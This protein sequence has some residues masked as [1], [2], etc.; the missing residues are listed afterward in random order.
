MKKT[1]L[2]NDLFWITFGL[3]VFI[4]GLNLGFGSFQAPEDGFMPCLAGL[5]MALLAIAD[6]TQGFHQKWESDRSDK[7]IWANIH[8]G[9]LLMT[10]AVL[11]LYQLF[12]TTLGFIIATF[13]L[14]LFL[15]QV[16]EPKSWGTVL[17]ASGLTTGLCYV[18]F[19]IGLDSQ[20]PS[21]FLG[22]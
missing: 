12:F 3:A 17:L 2:I 21:G 11:I 9:K 7:E 10:L 8:W 22:F 13:F 18:A 5:L 16:M 1:Y 19:K 20:L 15:F 4:E 14:L 6:L